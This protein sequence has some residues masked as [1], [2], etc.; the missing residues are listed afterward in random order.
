MCTSLNIGLV[1]EA[2]SGF[3]REHVP[4]ADDSSRRRPLLSVPVWGTRPLWHVPAV[5]HTA[6]YPGGRAVS[7]LRWQPV[8]SNQH[9]S[10]AMGHLSSMLGGVLQLGDIHGGVLQLEDIHGGELL[11]G[12]IQG[13]MA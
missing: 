6:D 4:A 11:L 9:V 13:V 8:R 2:V 1:D 3:H 7:Y 12:D 10:V 5:R